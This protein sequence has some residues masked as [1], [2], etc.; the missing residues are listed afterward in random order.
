M[1]EVKSLYIH[2]PFCKKKCN[3]CDFVSYAGKESLIDDYVEALIKEIRAL[4]RLHSGH[5]PLPEGEGLKTI[6]F[7]GGTPTLLSP[8]HFDKIISTIISHSSL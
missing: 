4:T 7:G 3:Y 6:Y 1:S 2:L 8:K 5:L